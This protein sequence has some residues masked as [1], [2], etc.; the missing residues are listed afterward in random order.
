MKPIKKLTGVI[1]SS[2]DL[3]PTAR[4]VT[5]KLSGP[6]DFMSGS[7]VNIFIE[8]AGEKLRR[9]F[10]IS[11]PEG[12]T[13][14]IALSIR[15]NPE[16]GVTPLFWQ[17]NIVGTKVEV[18]GPLG[19]NTADKMQSK[20]VY[21]FGY[22]IGAGVVKSLADHFVHKQDLQS[23]NIMTGNRNESE[24]IYRDY[25]DNLVSN[26]KS[27]HVHYVISSPESTTVHK[28]G[29]IQHHLEQ[30]D[31]NDSAVYVCGQEKACEDL[32]EQVKNQQPINCQFFIEGFH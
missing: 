29:Y 15:L 26:Q 24:I 6:I 13:D 30:F 11:S 7:F 4:E 17:E 22:G 10:S 23:L 25:F 9:A 5:L 3:S 8:K 16:G 32:V 27:T 18:M 14:T 31:F 28:T 1:T 21:L 19:L 20:K 2:I 12:V